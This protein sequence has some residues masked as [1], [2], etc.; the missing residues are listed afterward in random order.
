MAPALLAVLQLGRIHPD[1]VY[2][3]L[4]PAYWRVH[5]YGVLA[6]EWQ[7]GIRNWFIPFV[8]AGLLKACG[9]LGISHP[10]G[11]RAVLELP[12]LGLHLASLAAI[13]RFFSRRL[14][15]R[16]SLMA[17][18]TVGVYGPLLTFAGRTMSE[19]ISTSFFLIAVDL[20][21]R[22]PAAPNNRRSALVGGLMLGLTVV[23]RYGS[24]VLVLGA[25]LWLLARRRFLT[26]GLAIAGGLVIAAGLA[27]LDWRT[28]GKPLHSFFAYLDYNVISGKGAQR[29]GAE[30]FTFY[31]HILLRW[32]AFWI[33]PALYLEVR[34]VLR[35]RSA[36]LPLLV[37]FFY[38]LA[39]SITPHKE[40]RFVYPTLILLVVGT[41]PAL[42]SWLDALTRADLRAALSSLILCASVSPFFFMPDL[43]DDQFRALVKATR[44]E[45]ATGLLIVNEGLWGAGGFFYL[46]KRIPWATCDWAAD[47]NFRGAMSSPVINRVIT[48]EG[49]ELDAL[50]ANGFRVVDQIGRET[51][52]ER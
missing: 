12:Q 5:G 9:W 29:F 51:I 40:P 47:A 14:S 50:R 22:E 32:S 46:G 8:L 39:I 24:S 18:I 27:V 13:Y 31:G 28:W 20:L 26:A 34:Q 52:L 17:L 11:Y 38:L 3:A 35:E 37:A 21:D 15:P 6:W 42:F 23:T 43:R 2:Q 33:F 44:S 7:E 45:K 41:A 16:A 36:S 49:R 25:L 1:E 48:F 30:P 19:S 10:V 4:E